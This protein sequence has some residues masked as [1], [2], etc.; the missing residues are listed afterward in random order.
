VKLYTMTFEDFELS[1]EGTFDK[2]GTAEDRCGSSPCA[3]SRVA[4]SHIWSTW[5]S[6]LVRPDSLLELHPF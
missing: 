3:H 1:F 6:H 5:F 4:L 2:D